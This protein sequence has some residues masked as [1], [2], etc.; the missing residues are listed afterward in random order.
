[1]P[2]SP[3]GGGGGGKGGG[4]KPRSK[5][6]RPTSIEDVVA[7]N[8]EQQKDGAAAPKSGR[9]TLTLQEVRGCMGSAE[10]Q[11][12]RARLWPLRS[13]AAQTARNAAR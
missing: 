11:V 2:G 10:L 9:M 13:A 1:M 5:R 12:P 8:G 4:G 7:H 3:G 6:G